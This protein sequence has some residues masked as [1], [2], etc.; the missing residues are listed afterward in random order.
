MQVDDVASQLGS[1]SETLSDMEISK[2][3]KIN[4]KR[5]LN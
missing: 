4:R 5:R 3:R 1:I 2:K